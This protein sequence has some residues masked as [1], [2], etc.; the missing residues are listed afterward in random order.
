VLALKPS[1]PG[2]LAT[3]VVDTL[4]VAADPDALRSSHT[5]WVRSREWTEPLVDAVRG[6]GD[7]R[8]RSLGEALLADPGDPTRYR[9]LRSALLERDPGDRAVAALY[10]LAWRAECNSR[11]GHFL[12]SRYQPGERP[13]S[14]DDLRALPAG[15]RL[16]DGGNPEVLVVVPFRDRDAGGSRLRNLLACLLAL[17]DQSYA[18]AGYRVT[19]VESDDTPRWRDVIEPY[20]DHYIFAAKPGPFNKSWA[21]NAG[22]ANTPGQPVAICI[23]DG[24]V[25]VDRDFVARNAAR[26]ARP[27]TGGH[28]T[29]RDML[30]LDDHAASWALRERLLRR[31]PEVHL[32]HL[33]GFLVRR[34]PGCCLWVR[35][36]V[37]H[38]IGGMDERFEGWGFEDY[39][40]A[41]RYDMIACFDS[42]GDPLLH[43]P[44]PPAQRVL[45]EDGEEVNTRIP[46][47]TWKPNGPIGRL[48]RFSAQA[49]ARGTKSEPAGPPGVQGSPSTPSV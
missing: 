45:G 10:D 24:D 42:Y 26:F 6:S 34:P 44:H 33:R 20:A 32:D 23:L 18:R 11:L 22:V 35:A 49:G 9:E 28:L 17:R 13:M 5:Y 37:F 46:A 1:D 30:C 29:Y 36:E 12:G 19:V 38:R 2:G 48:D 40:F 7:A 4:V 27:G 47:L 3:A 43:L 8:L 41:H 14:A 15:G 25:L 21:V 16:P 31:S 39:D